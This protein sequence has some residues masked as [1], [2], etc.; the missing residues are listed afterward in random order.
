M[1]PDGA[2]FKI[3]RRL[4]LT[5]ALLIALILGG[6][7]LVIFQFESALRQTDRLTVVSQQLIAVLRL[8]QSLVSFHARLNELARFKDAHR[9][10]TEA[11]PLRM[12][13][14]EQT[15]QTRS[16]LGYLPAEFPV[17][18]AFLTALDTIETT[19][20]QQLQDISA[21]ATAGDWEAIRLRLDNE[22]KR[23]ESTT[24]AH[25]DSIDRDLDEELPHVV[26]NMRNVQR[27]IIFI[28]P[29]TALSTVF[30]AASFGWAIAR[31][32]LELRL[33]E[34]VRER[35]RI[36]RELHDS[37]LQSFQA[38]LMKFHGVTYLL[39]DHPQA[40]EQLEQVIEQ[41]RRAVTEGRDAVQ[42]LRSS[43][44]VANDLAKAIGALGEELAAE[45]TG[46]KSANFGVRVEGT[47]RNL[48]PL[49]RDEV[50]RIAGEALRNA[51]RHAEAESINVEIRYE[52]RQFFMRVRD[53]GKG[54]APE[55]LDGEGRPGHYGLPGMYER[56]KLVGAKLAV[57]SELNS[58][59][60]IELSVPGSVGF[61]R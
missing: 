18:P 3:G 29:A 48:V 25:V 59:T 6:N 47:P 43:T 46:M 1:P 24:S 30:I 26:A 40:R 31:R 45:Q 35:S 5:F 52:A 17:D 4:T 20:P 11:G 41:A 57:C 19:L 33:E 8:Q 22:L 15:R 42:G 2:Y 14:L 16:T 12:A 39:P 51:F 34:R 54:I 60:E 37:L 28:V 49:V 9:L 61:A 50:Y 21:L 44:T 58:G 56:A 10:V 55:I 13:L 38:V 53:N 7:G 36:A 32:I 27:R 23:I